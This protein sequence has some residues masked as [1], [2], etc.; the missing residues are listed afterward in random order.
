MREVSLF[1]TDLDNTLYDWFEAWHASFTAMLNELKRLTRLPESL[2]LEEIQSVFRQYGTVEYAFLIDELPCLRGPSGQVDVSRYS[3]AI[4]A[5]R[6]ARRA[7]LR[8]YPG[9]RETLGAIAEAG[10]L[11]VGYTES[12]WYYTRR[13]L[14]KLGLD[15][16]LDFVYSPA[17]HSLPRPVAEIR[18]LP[19]LDYVLAKTEHRVLAGGEMKPDPNVLRDIIRDVGGDPNR[20]VYVGDDLF[21]DVGMAKT[22]GVFAIWASY[23]VKVH[24]AR[25]DLLRR[26]S[27]WSKEEVERQRFAS[28]KTFEPDLQIASFAEIPDHCAFTDFS[29]LH[30]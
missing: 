16:I 11:V 6:E 13:R 15:R 21:K 12:R 20:C 19:P 30:E 5:Y 23:G 10:T 4:T 28:I 22:A 29:K 3:P 14:Q 17:D 1:I 2:L 27:H 18:T 26:V 25:Y 9:V 8:L 24:D 7:T